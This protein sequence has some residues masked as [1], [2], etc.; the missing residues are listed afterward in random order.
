MK[1][2]RNASG[3]FA[4][5][6]KGGPG[7]PRKHY[8]ELPLPEDQDAP[9]GPDQSASAVAGP[10]LD[11]A[12]PKKIDVARFRALF[13][14]VPLADVAARYGMREGLLSKWESSDEEY[15]RCLANSTQRKLEDAFSEG[16]QF[17]R[18][19]NLEYLLM[20]DTLARTCTDPRTRRAALRDLL[21]LQGLTNI[22]QPVMPRRSMRYIWPSREPFGSEPTRRRS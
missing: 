19:N 10:A 9:D 14:N 4:P 20:L 7:R 3:L 15:Q 18:A 2:G 12:P 17:I 13:P 6:N 8:A 21:E 11:W 1:S 22:E 16:L 5:G